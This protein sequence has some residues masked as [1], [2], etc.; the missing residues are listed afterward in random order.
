MEEKTKKEKAG[1][2]M[3]TQIFKL[4]MFWT[5]SRKRIWEDIGNKIN[6]KRK[7]ER[8]LRQMPEEELSK[9]IFSYHPWGS[10]DIGGPQ[11]WRTEAGTG[12]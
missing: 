4:H 6:Y 2:S 1:Y 10:S 7:M 8:T 3:V 12:L 9:T 5:R 11:K